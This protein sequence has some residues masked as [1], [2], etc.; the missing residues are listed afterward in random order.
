MVNINWHKGAQAFVDGLASDNPAPGGGAAGAFC[1][2]T[3]TGLAMMAISITL[4][5]SDLDVNKKNSLKKTLDL[6]YNLKE[7]LLINAKEDAKAYENVV[8]ARKLPKTS[9]ERTVFLQE[10]LK[11]AAL[12]PVTCAKDTVEVIKNLN[13][14]E[15]QIS[16]AIISDVNCSK[17]LLKAALFCCVENIKANQIYIKDEA[18]K[19]EL[20]KNIN[21]I[22]KFC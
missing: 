9:K 2:A 11:Q 13:T 17:K 5:R 1:A 8:S 19:K 16:K 3:G 20:E 15:K 10:A 4:K 14:V 6:L 18:F 7:N 12:V 22:E 21:F